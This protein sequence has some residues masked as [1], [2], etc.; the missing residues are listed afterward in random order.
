MLTDQEQDYLIPADPVLQA[1][2]FLQPKT[3]SRFPLNGQ[4][5]SSNNFQID[6]SSVNSQT[7][8]GGAVITP[9][10]ESVKEVQI[11]SSTYSAEDG[12]NSGAQIKVVSQNE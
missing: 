10:Q 9:T 3:V 5:V 12:R 11:T 1:I 6:G 7:W 8:G 2:R 4:R